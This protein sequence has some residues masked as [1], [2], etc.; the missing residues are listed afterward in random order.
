[1]LRYP[2]ARA[3]GDTEDFH[4]EVVADPYRWLEDSR[5]PDTTAWVAAQN[6]L[7]RTVLDST[8]EVPSLRQRVTGLTDYPRHQVPFERGGRWFSFRNSGLQAQAVLYVADSPDGAGRPLLDPNQLSADGTVAV[9]GTAVTEDGTLLAY[10]TSGS[11]SDWQTWRV[12]DIAT[13]ADL[14]DVVHWS[15]YSAAAWRGDNSGFYYAAPEPPA[16]GTEYSAQH[17]LQR[18]MFHQLGT[19]QGDD[20]MIYAAPLRRDWMPQAHVTE[21]GR[22]LVITVYRGTAPEARVLIAD[23][24]GE[25][26]SLRPLVGG[27]A[28]TADV[29]T[30]IGSMFYLVTDD[31]ADR[32][33]L[34]AVDPA[35]PARENWREVI[36]ETGDSLRSVH[37]CGGRFVCHYLHDA[38]SVLRVHAADGAPAGQ[39]PLPPYC[40]VAGLTGRGRSELMHAGVTSF[41]E[42]GAIWAHDLGTGGTR[43]LRPSAAPVDPGQ[44]RTERVRVRSADGTMVPVFLIRRRELRRSGDQPALLYGYGGFDIPVTPAFSV[45]QAAWL[46]LGG[47]LAVANL[48]GGGEF[49]RAWHDAGRLGAK[50]HT[51]DDFCACARWLADSGWSR[52]GRIAIMGGSNGGLAVGACLTQH[53]ELFGACVAVVGV[54]DMLRFHQFTIGRA[55][56]SDYGDPADPEQYRW[57]RSYSPLHNL[58]PGTGY[59]ATL[60][61][62]G[63]H[64]DRVVPGHSFKFAAALQAA[65]GGDAPVL[66]RTAASAGHGAGKPTFKIIEESADI[67]AFLRLALGL[68]QRAGGQD[69]DVEGAGDGDCPV[70]CETGGQ[71]G[72]AAGRGR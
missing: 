1:M 33:R 24:A 67:L 42:S 28:S 29:V 41:T 22:F 68:H 31:G 51:F 5:A 49:G 11:G 3:A 57:L 37:W 62:T 60:L 55:W 36:A 15:R 70:G 34:V 27:F 14:A 17:G 52:P 72:R 7:T 35:A 43:L 66:L 8:G 23:L 30:A 59:P 38:H 13:G 69:G 58:R 6:A 45:L 46:Q 54:L 64:D 44:F 47:V 18:V 9:S 19:G 21:D 39:I 26:P 56:I 53:P 61:L 48:R 63:D 20:Q 16:R 2:A 71:P 12:R 4:G 65:Q 40:S 50:Q 32:Q 25:A 10:A